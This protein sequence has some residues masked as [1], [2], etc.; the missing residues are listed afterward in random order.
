MKETSQPSFPIFLCNLQSNQ[1]GFKTNKKVM[2]TLTASLL[3]IVVMITNVQVSHAITWSNDIRLTSDPGEDQD[4]AITQTS[5]G[6]IWVTWHSRRTGNYDIFYKVFDGSSWSN[7]VQL[8]FD[9]NEDLHPSILQTSDG[10]IWIIWNS[11]RTGNWNI[12]L[13]YKTSTDNGASWTDD[14]Q[15]T[16]DP[17]FD[18]YPSIMQSSDGKVWV[19]WT[20][21]RTQ[22][23]IPPDPTYI[24]TVDIYYKFSSDAGQ[25]WSDDILL[26]TGYK[27]NYRNDLYPSCMQAANGSIWMVWT[28]EKETAAGMDIYYK[29]Y[30]G[31][32]WSWEVRL[33][34][35]SGNTHPFIMQTANERIWIFWDSDR[36]I[37]NNI[38]YIVFDG[39]WSN[40][41][42][43]TTALEDDAFPSAMQANDLTIWVVWSSPRYPQL[44]YDIFYRTGM[45]LHDLAVLSVTPPS[46][47]NNTLAYR[48]EVAYIEVGVQNDGEAKETFQ[49]EVYV[50]SSRIETRTVSLDHGL[51]YSMRFD[52]DTTGVKPG[53]YVA[54]ATVVPV[55]GETDVADNSLTGEPFEVRIRGDLCGV[56]SNV[57]KPIPDGRVD[58]VDFVTAIGHFGTFNPTWHPVWGPA[59]D[60]NEDGEVDID[61]IV[62]ICIHFGEI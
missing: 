20:S 22:T 15:L 44:V 43:L 54:S 10:K 1:S 34:T 47:N 32:G 29:I 50:N 58:I 7:D 19:F 26:V 42:R 45:E 14:T 48:G 55:L 8:T 60:V 36:D 25:T 28:K 13:F 51:Y 49:V 21:S 12:D 33:T 17:G 56:Y 2:F 24:P 5:N 39:S 40:E 4:P 6:K 53:K 57:V 46:H 23:P 3:L 11:N 16:T 61:D 59:C 52:W 31:T 27:N 9:P 35:Y 30:N 37:N 18:G 38:Y 62:I 41:T